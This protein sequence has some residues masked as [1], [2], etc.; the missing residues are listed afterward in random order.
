LSQFLKAPGVYPQPLLDAQAEPF[1]VHVQPAFAY[2]LAQPVEGVG[3]MAAGVGRLAARPE[4]FGH[5]FAGLGGIVVNEQIG[6]QA[7]GF[8]TDSLVGTITLP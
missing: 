5:D 8:A 2:R 4:G 3:E 6:K 7:Q 1:P